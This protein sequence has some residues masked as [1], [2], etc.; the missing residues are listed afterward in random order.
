MHERRSFFNKRK[1]RLMGRERCFIVRIYRRDE[2]DA[3]RIVG[4][5][6]IVDNGRS[7]AI[8]S[9]D[10]LWRIMDRYTPGNGRTGQRRAAME[11]RKE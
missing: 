8:R 3:R 5:V 7:K 11:L 4:I 2:L 6:Q 1:A 10:E 9:P